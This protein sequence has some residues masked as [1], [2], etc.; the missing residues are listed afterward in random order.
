MLYDEVDLI[1]QR[2]EP[3]SRRS[4]EIYLYNPEY[5]E[6]GEDTRNL[7]LMMGFGPELGLQEDRRLVAADGSDH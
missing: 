3:V 5:E 4:R 2:E 7:E 1:A 6:E